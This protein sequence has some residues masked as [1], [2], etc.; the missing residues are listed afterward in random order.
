MTDNEKIFTENDL[1]PIPE[2][3]EE[4]TL[5]D[6]TERKPRSFRA[7]VCDKLSRFFIKRRN[8]T[9]MDINDQI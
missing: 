5:I 4:I 7:R 1:N 6:T 8:Y 2:D 9:D 3:E